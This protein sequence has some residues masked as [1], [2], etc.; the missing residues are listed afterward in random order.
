M[1]EGNTNSMHKIFYKPHGIF[2]STAIAMFISLLTAFNGV[3]LGNS[4]LFPTFGCYYAGSDEYLA[5]SSD[6]GTIEQSAI[7]NDIGMIYHNLKKANIIFIGNSR[8]QMGWDYHLLNKQCA[9]NNIHIYNLSCGNGEGSLFFLYYIRLHPIFGKI[10]L[11]NVDKNFQVVSGPAKDAMRHDKAYHIKDFLKKNSFIRVKSMFDYFFPETMYSWFDA[12]RPEA[13]IYRR[14]SDGFWNF[15]Y[16][17]DYVNKISP[18]HEGVQCAE[19]YNHSISLYYNSNLKQLIDELRK[20]KC[21]VILT[22]IP[23]TDSH[24]LDVEE[25]GLYENLPVIVYKNRYSTL[26]TLDG[27]HLSNASATEFTADIFPK[28]TKLYHAILAAHQQ[29]HTVFSD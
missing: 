27:S 8:M 28:I 26:H 23:T 3:F 15:K 12:K 7:F 17:N 21:F 6:I 18:K 5:Y 19:V 9:S 14:F 22:Q 13:V 24:P 2:I 20:Q 4:F 10:V 1:M 16:Y 25:I 11:I 29:D